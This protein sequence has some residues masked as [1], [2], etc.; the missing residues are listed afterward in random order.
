MAA[1]RHRCRLAGAVLVALAAAASCSSSDGRSAPS[2]PTTTTTPTV[3]RP[4]TTAPSTVPS[5]PDAGGAVNGIRLAH[6]ARPVAAAG[7]AVVGGT[8][9]DAAGVQAVVDRLPSWDPGAAQ[10]VAFDWPASTLSPPLAP[11]TQVP[12]ATG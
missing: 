10:V 1:A 4:V 12:L 11:T 5:G 6:A 3:S 9:L 7:V 8:P 2:T